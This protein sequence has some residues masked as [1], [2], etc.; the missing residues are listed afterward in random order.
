MTKRTLLLLALAATTGVP[1]LAA[2]STTQSQAPLPPA[3]VEQPYG[4]PV[5]AAPGGDIPGAPPASTSGP[6]SGSVGSNTAPQP[7]AASNGGL[8]TRPGY[9]PG[10]PPPVVAEQAPP[11]AASSSDAT[12]SASGV[13]V[14]LT[15][16]APTAAAATPRATVV[17]TGSRAPWAT[18]LADRAPRTPAAVEAPAPVRALQA[19]GSSVIAPGQA[20]RRSDT[21]PKTAPD[22]KPDS[23]ASGS[24]T[25][26]S[27]TSDSATA[28]PSLVVALTDPAAVVVRL[29]PRV[30]DD[31]SRSH[32]LHRP[33]EA[34]DP[35]DG[36]AAEPT[37]SASARA[38][39]AAKPAA[40]TKNL[41]AQPSP[42]PGGATAGRKPQPAGR[43][44]PTPTP[45]P[46]MRTADW[47]M[48]GFVL[49]V[50]QLP[51]PATT[52]AAPA[53]RHALAVS[54]AARPSSPRPDAGSL[55]RWAA[56]LEKAAQVAPDRPTAEHL[57]TVSR[58]AAG[59]A[60]VP[61]AGRA[62]AQLSNYY[63]MATARDLRVNLPARFGVALLG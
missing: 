44:T 24:S 42:L 22:S 19:A 63:V 35:E 26:D 41:S 13:A 8:T 43:A 33:S 25:S 46:R 11:A 50:K 53:F 15:G 14:P 48:P 1:A 60:R 58:Y 30:T 29:G 32:T 27:S 62:K 61:L 4:T 17:G 2:C 37:A 31:A 6:R 51:V 3:A 12:Q 56:S 38:R 34:R 21:A 18:L 45:Q 47:R 57:R 16:P 39:P 54:L 20:K 36:A 28:R 5:P 52:N 59:L 49:P 55:L 10:T 23:S 40:A 9:V 7:V